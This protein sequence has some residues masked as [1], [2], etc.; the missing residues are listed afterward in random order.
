MESYLN[1]DNTAPDE[2][3]KNEI[4][5]ELSKMSFED[6]K[7][8]KE[9]LGSKVYKE[10]MFGSKAVTK[11]EFKRMNKNRPR[12]VSSKV[13][14]VFHTKPA[15]QTSLDPRFSSLYGKFNKKHFDNTYGFL[16]DMRK[17]ERK[18]LEKML[19][20]ETDSKKVENI[21][22]LI[23]RMKNQDM[24]EERRNK[25][26]EREENER[27]EQIKALESGQRPHFKTKYEKKIVD[28][29]DKYTALKKTGKVQKFIEKKRKQEAIKEKKRKKY[30]LN[31]NAET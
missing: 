4:R 10:A 19:S 11:T 15:K 7:N 2:S 22:Y 24:E 8:L 26:L 29:V 1:E 3:E 13:K 9:K 17:N 27:Q 20:K 18:Q 31:N 25:R 14:P 30:F 16:T 23:Q 12:E 21:K 28:L 5:S 6:L